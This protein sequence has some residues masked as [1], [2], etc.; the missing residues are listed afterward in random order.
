MRGIGCP[1]GREEHRGQDRTWRAFD[2]G[3]GKYKGSKQDSQTEMREEAE[4]RA[5]GSK[6]HAKE[7]V[8]KESWRAACAVVSERD[9]RAQRQPEQQSRDCG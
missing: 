7:S 2:S 3:A 5:K 4:V 8:Q 6:R 1:K 9:F